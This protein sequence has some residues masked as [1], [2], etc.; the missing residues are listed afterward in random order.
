MTY[1]LRWAARPIHLL[2]NRLEPL[3]GKNSAGLSLDTQ[4]L[5]LKSSQVRAKGMESKAYACL[6]FPVHF[7]LLVS[8]LRNTLLYN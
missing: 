7:D 4:M 8:M 2:Y 6:F 5:A 1:R 3:A